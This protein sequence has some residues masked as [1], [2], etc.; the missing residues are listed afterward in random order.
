MDAKLMWDER[1]EIACDAH[2]PN[3]GSDTRVWGGW[4]KISKREADEFEREVG[5]QVECE[6]CRAIKRNR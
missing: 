5:R 2:A 6:T 4:R 1:G 3:A